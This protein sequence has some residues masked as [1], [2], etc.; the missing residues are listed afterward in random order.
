MVFYF[1]LTT[2]YALFLCQRT[3]HV[4]DD[5]LECPERHFCL[6]SMDT[7]NGFI[8]AS[9]VNF[10]LALFNSLTF[11]RWWDMRSKV[12]VVM[13][14]SN[15]IAVQIAAYCRGE[16][17]GAASARKTLLRYVN[18]AHAL[19]YKQANK[20]EDMSD[21]LDSGLMTELEWDVLRPLVSRYMMVYFWLSDLIH[22]CA[23]NGVFMY[24]GTT[25]RFLQENVTAMRGAA[26]DVFMY[27]NTQIPY[28]YVHLIT[29]ITKIHLILISMNS[30]AWV[31]QG[32]QEAPH[33]AGLSGIFWGYA[34][35]FVSVVAYEGLLQIHAVLAK[36]FGSGHS[37]FPSEVFFGG[38]HKSTTT[39]AGIVDRRPYKNFFDKTSRQEN[40]A[41]KYRTP[42]EYEDH[43]EPTPF[44]QHRGASFS[45]SRNP[46]DYFELSSI[47]PS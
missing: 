9:L 37:A 30:A 42:F 7:P 28:I 43:A 34:R 6:P 19:L 29:V 15:D 14:R 26:A 13:G 12:G 5:R 1:S 40:D 32:F 4:G 11:S 25:I 44:T 33:G 2:V 36:P 24:P 35:L 16:A 10:L 21:L 20:D 46:S 31:G 22:Q 45:P 23:E 3:C 18:L 27:L 39:V 38:V 47:R 8:W 41:S 17:E